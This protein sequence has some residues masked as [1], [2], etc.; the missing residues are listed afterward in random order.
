MSV[1]LQN[2]SVFSCIFAR[3][4]SIQVGSLK[5]KNWPHGRVGDTTL[6]VKSSLFSIKTF[7]HSFERTEVWKHCIDL[8]ELTAVWGGVKARGVKN[9]KSSVKMMYFN[10]FDANFDVRSSLFSI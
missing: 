2:F 5:V 4:R 9:S 3:A 10:S 1:F 6:D 7:S 8:S